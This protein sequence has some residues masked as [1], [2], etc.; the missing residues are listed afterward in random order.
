[1]LQGVVVPGLPAV[2][3]VSLWVGREAVCVLWKVVVLVV[4]REEVGWQ[5]RLSC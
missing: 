4:G 3:R 5:A 2:A 1:M